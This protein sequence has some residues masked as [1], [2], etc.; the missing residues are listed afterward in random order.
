[1]RRLIRAYLVTGCLHCGEGG[2]RFKVNCHY[3][4]VAVWDLRSGLRSPSICLRSQYILFNLTDFIN[5]SFE[6]KSYVIFSSELNSLSL[7]AKNSMSL[8]EM[9]E[10][11]RPTN[12]N[13]WE[14]SESY[15]FKC[16]KR[17]DEVHV[18]EAV[19]YMKRECTR[20]NAEEA[21]AHPTA[22]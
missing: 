3:H 9:L 6:I 20:R 5:S 2:T 7:D 21:L 22:T 1:M 4:S 8:L 13:D 18:S 11:Q 14:H 15:S 19:F 16:C 10:S 12:L 17:F